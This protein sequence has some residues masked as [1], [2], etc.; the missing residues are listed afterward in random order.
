MNINQNIRNEKKNIEQ[1]IECSYKITHI[2][3]VLYPRFHTHFLNLFQFKVQEK[4]YYYQ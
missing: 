4:F 1:L 2:S 3:A